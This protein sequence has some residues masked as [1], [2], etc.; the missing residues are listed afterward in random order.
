SCGLFC[1]LPACFVLRRYS[2]PLPAVIAFSFL[3][4]CLFHFPF[5]QNLFGDFGHISRL[6]DLFWW[7]IEDTILPNWHQQ[8]YRYDVILLIVSALIGLLFMRDWRRGML[9]SLGASLIL[10]PV[11]NAWYVAWILPVATWGRAF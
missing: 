7:L 11:L 9:W 6:N 3:L 8:Y 4:Y 1:L 5:A 10:A 2:I